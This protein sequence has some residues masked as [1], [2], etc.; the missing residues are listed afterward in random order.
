MAFVV[1]STSVWPF[2]APVFNRGT[3][4]A[5]QTRFDGDGVCR[6]NTDYTC[7]PAAAVTALRR[8]N[9]AAEEGE[10]AVLAHTST[11]IGTPPDLLCAALQKRYAAEGL[12]CAY[13][14]FRNLDELKAAGL[15]LAVTKFALFVDHY[16]V[17]LE[18]TDTEV[19]VADPLYGKQTY[20]R[21]QFQNR[22]RYCGI[23]LSRDVRKDRP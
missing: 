20:S 19:R 23:V 6:Q 4:R 2:L 9:Y 15:I 21:E 7:G 12:H 17:V 8:L 10:L 18:V 14:H 11:A 13:R 16:V 1:T 5:M 3:L 22:W